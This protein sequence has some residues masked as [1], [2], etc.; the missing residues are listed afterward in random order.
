MELREV[1]APLIE[2]NSIRWLADQVGVHESRVR[3]VLKQKFV[4]QELVEDWLDALDLHYALY[5]TSLTLIPNP[6][7]ERN[8][9]GEC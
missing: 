1:L 9:D 8:H 4:T 2:A 3:R 5:D 6:Y 7:Y